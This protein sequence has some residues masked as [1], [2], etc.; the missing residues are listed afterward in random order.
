MRQ[1]LALGLA[2]TAA[3]LAGAAMAGEG[4]VTMDT[5]DTFYKLRGGLNR[6]RETFLRTGQGRVAFLG[7]S[8]TKMAGWR[9]LT[10]ET[11][12][13]RF[14]K[15]DFEFVNAGIGGT[16]STLG[17]F[18][19]EEDVFGRGP[20]DLLFLEYAVNDSGAAG[21]DNR[22]IRAMEGIV[23]RARRLNPSIDILIL[24]F[25]DRNKVEAITEGETPAVIVDHERVAA[26]YELPA[27]N[28]AADI[29]R[30][31]NADEFAW[32]RFAGDAC[33]P[34]PFGHE[35]YAER[36]TSFLDVAWADETPSDAPPSRPLPIPLDPRN[37]E[38]GSFVELDEAKSVSGWTRIN[39][40][41]A[42]KKCNYEG[43]VDVFAADSPGAVLE[44]PFSGRVIG[45]SAF[46]GMDAGVLECVVD[47][48]PPRR[49]DLFDMYCKQFHRPV[50]RILAEDLP[51]GPHLLSLRV[52]DTKNAA[53]DG[54]AARIGRFLVSAEGAA[55]AGD[56]QSGAALRSLAPEKIL[57]K[58]DLA[59]PG[60]E[61]VR[62]KASQGD[63]PGALAALLAY[64]RDEYPLPET[65]GRASQSDIE[66]ADATVNHVFQW[67]PYEPAQ[68]G[69][70]VDWAWDPRGD[71]EWV[72]A[73]YR[74]YWA[75][76]L[77]RAYGAT[78]DEKYVRAFVELTADWIAKHPLE[79]R[80]R[81]HPVYTYWRGFPWLD[82]QT[83]IRATSLCEAF[84]VLVHG[85]AFTPAFL[86][87]FL[88]SLY[89]H[90]AKTERFPMGKIHNKAIFEQRG[91]VNV[92]FT[93]PE[94]EESRAWLKLALERSRENLLAQTTTDGV[95]REWS[96]G[97]HSG[98]LRDAVEIMQRMEAVGIPV[99]QDYCERVRAMYD[100][101]FAIATPELGYTM[102]GDASRPAAVPD[103]R[104]RWPLYNTLVA[105]SELLNDP[106]YAARARLE[107]PALPEQTSY[108][109]SE[110][111]M[112]AL[113]S[114]WG[115][116]QVYLALH[117]S[118]P[119]I[120]SHDQADNGTFELYAYGRWLMPDTGFY[121]YGHDPE[122]RAWHRRTSVHQTLTL[123]GQD[124]AVA[125]KELLWH[126]AP[127]LDAVVVE[128]ASYDKLV[129]RRTIWFIE[130]AF[131][132]VLDEAIGHAAGALDLHFQFAPGA[133]QINASRHWAATGFD[134]ANVLVWASPD[135][136]V[137]V[138][139]EEGW[140]A[141][142][143]GH[144]TERRAF[145]F[146]H[147]G[148]A[149]A[150][151]LTLL[152]PY[153][154]CAVPEVSASLVGS[155]TVGDER[156]ET[157]VEAFGKAWRLGRDVAQGQAWCVPE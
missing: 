76:P 127:G 116:E 78:R 60:L 104:A 36:I 153:R 85:D 38:Y 140:F 51:R 101:L 50:C 52:A 95:Q 118:P 93:F 115:P 16:N 65:P 83:G 2:A 120:S 129:H 6:C 1:M 17:A 53:S 4:G 157:H 62:A 46:A 138:E 56:A 121:T 47:G 96:G 89:D 42:E 18:R 142:K 15:V 156:V 11:L 124:T 108:A 81:T 125:G 141:W 88:A 133:A 100:Y 113:R 68:Y 7:G 111:G 122:A 29:T 82:I 112:Y 22:R 37:Y 9:D 145:R 105:A 74:F 150:S 54:Y 117:C 126:A 123:N 66:S 67:G 61:S 5:W 97:Y 70:D 147:R 34:L 155:F 24:Y 102:F 44:V 57:A 10:Y 55:P 131:F 144:R 75:G 39:A 48:G 32:N 139:E 91:F 13:K 103:D 79:E 86:G 92:A 28:L 98:V 151:F 19:F 80:E 107:R 132:A 71:I 94:F 135:A 59:A 72:A 119:A 148:V 146:R 109:F 64:Y 41:D 21:P 154:G 114:D 87:V 84:P 137:D 106:K 27:L 99:P 25:A 69:P 12:R 77:V 23:R 33:H 128:N 45:I 40:W 134:D 49:I 136:P 90:Q 58:L 130:S 43:S 73:I 31:L 63:E 20:V 143:Y 110:A 149:P 35:C 30:R 26:Y 152:V 3:L 14:P 8:I